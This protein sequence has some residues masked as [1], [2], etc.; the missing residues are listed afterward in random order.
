VCHHET[1][2][3]RRTPDTHGPGAG[4]A[5]TKYGILSYSVQVSGSRS[6][7]RTLVHVG[8]Q[9]IYDR[10]G[11]LTAYELLFRD[12]PGADTAARRN[13]TAS[14]RVMVAAF[15]EFGLEQLVGSRLC[16]IN[17]TREFLVGELALPFGPSRVVLEILETIDVDDRVIAGVT[18]LAEQG[19]KI[20]LDDFERGGHERLLDLADYIK[21]DILG[22]TPDAVADLAGWCHG[23]SRAELIAERLESD[24]DLRLA[25]DAG[26]DLFQGYVLGRPK[27]MSTVGISAARISRLRLLSA[28]AV[29]VVDFDEVVSLISRD[30]TVTYRLL[31]ATNAAA[32]GLRVRVA[33]VQEAAIMLGLDK[34]RRWVT[35]ML[36]SDMAEASEDQ[37]TATMT[38]A[39]ACQILAE[40]LGRPGDAAFTM[41][42]LSGVADLIGQPASELASH[43]PLAH[44]VHSALTDGT[45]D[46]GP[47]LLAVRDYERGLIEAGAA[48]VPAERLVSAYLS[49]IGWS[50][51][52][53]TG[54]LP[55]PP[56]PPALNSAAPGDP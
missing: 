24:E 29:D 47:V 49:A 4:F 21:I 45:G 34:V 12:N 41:G 3:T 20:A 48:L 15:T 35:L 55:E 46:L 6:D 53:L 28:L 1:R 43:L 7:D 44:A 27:V 36:I 25:L 52:A 33:S 39:R 31:Q 17:L 37:L 42:L 38:R 23:H 19:Y 9:P 32:S 51:D 14:S 50:T 22:V 5:R 30:P 18:A 56:P 2:P 54:A 13:A 40:L 16:F 8:R 26:F 11:R 10:A